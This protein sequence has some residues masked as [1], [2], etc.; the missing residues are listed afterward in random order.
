MFGLST[1]CSADNIPQM[2]QKID[3]I[4]KN[5]DSMGFIET[6]QSYQEVISYKPLV[7]QC[8]NQY[9]HEIN[10]LK[11]ESSELQPITNDVYGLEKKQKIMTKLSNANDQKAF[12][13]YLKNK[14]PK[15][16]TQIYRKKQQIFLYRLYHKNIS[17]FDLIQQSSISFK[18]ALFNST[19][20]SNYLEQSNLFLQ[21]KSILI[22]L[23]YFLLLKILA[24]YSPAF[25]GFNTPFNLQHCLL[26]LSLFWTL[27]PIHYIV[28]YNIY[29]NFHDRL[30][31]FSLHMPYFYITCAFFSTILYRNLH[32]KYSFK[33]YTLVGLQ[34]ILL[35]CLGYFT[36]GFK[37]IMFNHLP[38]T[39]MAYYQYMIL[40]IL[41][42]L[43]C[44]TLYWLYY[45]LFNLSFVQH[46]AYRLVF[47]LPI[48]IL[49]IGFCGY[50]NFAVSINFILIISLI[51]SL[52]LF[53][54][55]QFCS[56]LS[57]IFLSQKKHSIFF[58]LFGLN[59]KLALF[60]LKILIYFIIF[61]QGSIILMSSILGL[62]FYMTDIVDIYYYVVIYKFSFLPTTIQEFL[63]AFALIIVLN[64]F[65]FFLSNFIA[66]KV[67][68]NTHSIE[69][70][71]EI[72][73]V[74]GYVFIILYVL[75]YL[76][77]PFQN[78][79]VLMGGLSIGIGLG[80]KNI[81]SNFI[82]SIILMTHRPFE[83][84]DF[85]QIESTKGYVKKISLLETYLETL[86]NNI[87]IMPNQKIASSVVQNF[88]YANKT[89]YKVHLCYV[90]NQ[91]N[92]KNEVKIKNSLEQFLSK[93]SS[94]IS[95]EKHSTKI[96]FSLTE[97]S[98]DSYRL[99]IIFSI[100]NTKHVKEP[101][102]KINREIFNLLQSFNPGVI[103]EKIEYPIES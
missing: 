9:S 22:V 99:E 5:L 51:L 92:I 2:N 60:H 27:L 24:R 28:L 67:I 87:I 30:L 94:V 50:I 20:W 26:V 38:E 34:M 64:M 31:S 18:D 25:S 77:L 39:L 91:L 32:F 62:I 69:K 75:Y 44:L 13:L 36:Y 53:F 55:H 101:L 14:I 8:V 76:G 16:L 54:L 37:Y 88:T 52:I 11:Q 7:E 59:E 93:Q 49:F 58:R 103:F 12:C 86:D 82:S 89:Y 68:K 21:P 10:Q 6:Y 3:A 63:L 66:H 98:M 84:G 81:L 96:I 73:R 4:E 15:L 85:I 40:I 95:N 35:I 42:P 45:R 80:L 56:T 83:I 100:D 48:L 74:I 70:S 43:V 102:I 78:L 19:Q 97:N 90:L 1:T 41:Q 72:L 47:I 57:N 29:M 17:L 65:N 46:Q 79:F 71:V 23:L 33:D 61:L